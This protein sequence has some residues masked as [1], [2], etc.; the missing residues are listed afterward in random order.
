MLNRLRPTFVMQVTEDTG[1]PAGDVARAFTIIR[2]S[3]D[4]RTIW[5]EIESLD[6]RL[7][8]AVQTEMMVSVGLLLERATIWL[9]RS[10]Y[11]KLDIAS[12]VA[13]FKPRIATLSE[14]LDQVLPASLL[15]ALRVREAELVEDGIPES[16]AHRV[17][18]LDVMSAAMDI[19]R[20]ARAGKAPGVVEDVARVYF[21]VGARFGLDRL[22]AVSASIAAE[23]PWQK[24]AVAAVVD[25]LF[26]Y[27]SVLASRVISEANGARDGDP[28]DRWLAARGR[29]VDRID[30]TMTDVRSAPAVDLA[31]LTVAT[32][33]LRALV[34]S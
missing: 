29:V 15:A 6:N 32:R 21:G 14:R 23:T 31:M 22:R 9:L 8:A 5:A 25:D 20:I 33:Q 1:K 13:E 16:L 30:Q 27:Q 7:P 18:S 24:A 17:A 4:L 12:Y 10:G 26:N 19:V 34:E 2:E 28:V 11:E 3:F